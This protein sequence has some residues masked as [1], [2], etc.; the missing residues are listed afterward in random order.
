MAEVSTTSAS[1]GTEQMTGNSEDQRVVEVDP[2]AQRSIETDRV[3]TTQVEAA[4]SFEEEVSSQGTTI[5][6]INKESDS[7]FTVRI[8]R[9]ESP[10][11]DTSTEA[12]VSD[13]QMVIQSSELNTSQEEHGV[14]GATEVTPIITTAA[15]I[16]QEG[17]QIDTTGMGSHHVKM[18]PS[19]GQ[20]LQ[21]QPE[22]ATVPSGQGMT[23][24]QSLVQGS[25]RPGEG[26]SENI[27]MIAPVPE[28]P[29]QSAQSTL[30]QLVEVAS[31]SSPLITT[32]KPSEKPIGG[33][34]PPTSETL[35]SVHVQNVPGGVPIIK[36]VTPS[37]IQSLQSQSMQAQS[38]TLLAKIQEL[39][40]Q[41]VQQQGTGTS[42]GTLPILLPQAS[43]ASPEPLALPQQV[44]AMAA[45]SQ[46]KLTDSIVAHIAKQTVNKVVQTTNTTTVKAQPTLIQSAVSALA[47]TTST[48]SGV[49]Q[50]RVQQ[51]ADVVLQSA[52]LL[53][54]PSH[55]TTTRLPAG[56]TIGRT[57][58]GQ[59]VIT[60]M[61]SPTAQSS[62]GHAAQTN[63]TLQPPV[64][65]RLTPRCLVCG[66]KSSGVHYGVLACEGC[67]V[68]LRKMY[69]FSCCKIDNAQW[70]N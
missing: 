27:R 15:S 31:A 34:K 62:Q 9:N 49:Q 57:A 28:V 17:H 10:N 68:K 13:S 50:I 54:L 67:K 33:L 55:L 6:V 66:D 5:Q 59:M 64:E 1:D 52:D 30:A 4:G 48:S 70:P 45:Q 60:P 58:S 41:A 65:S 40:P 8:V 7:S 43:V 53:T 39:L 24:M 25:N 29:T 46:P 19:T 56:T 23:I 37:N 38:M 22:S 11:A 20:L 12:V 35:Q 51:G 63:L 61:M 2:H 16:K 18:E 32:S 42:G 36:H 3:S 21:L 26:S 69:K 44:I 47:S 14:E